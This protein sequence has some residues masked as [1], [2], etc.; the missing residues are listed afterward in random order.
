MKRALKYGLLVAVIIAV[1]ITLKHWGLHLD[2]ARGATFDLV[3]FNVAAIIGL[4]LGIID[5]RAANNG[6]LSFGE[7]MKTGVAIAVTYAVLTAIYFA[8]VLVVVGP[9]LMQ[10]AGHVGPGGEITGPILIKAF[11]GLIIGM[12]LIGAIL[13]VFVSLVLK[14]KL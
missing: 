1:W 6:A 5:K 9:V 13:S 4:A 2:Q 7:G 14:R 11:A 3:V 8:V 12:A 10:Q